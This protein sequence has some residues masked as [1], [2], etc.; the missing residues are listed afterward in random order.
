[1]AKSEQS[2]LE[3]YHFEGGD[4][5]DEVEDGIRRDLGHEQ[6]LLLIMQE[7]MKLRAE[8]RYYC[9]HR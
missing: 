5:A 9:R 2:F 4:S 8:G 3:G 7:D 6:R 1:M